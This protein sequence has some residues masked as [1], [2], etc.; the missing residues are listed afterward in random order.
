MLQRFPGS[1]Q[2]PKQADIYATISP[3][4]VLAAHV[5][6]GHLIEAVDR[7]PFL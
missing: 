5:Q 2:F 4:R 6:Y 3:R 7:H 1:D